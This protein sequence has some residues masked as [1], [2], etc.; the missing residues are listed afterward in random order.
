MNQKAV[1]S[2][3][4]SANCVFPTPVKVLST[5]PVKYQLATPSILLHWYLVKVPLPPQ[6][7]SLQAVSAPQKV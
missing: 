1:L 6:L 7:N 4:H 2:T 5:L 3:Q